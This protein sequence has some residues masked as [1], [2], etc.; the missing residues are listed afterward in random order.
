VKEERAKQQTALTELNETLY[1]K[2]EK[3]L[4][5][6]NDISK[7]DYV[8][9][10]NGGAIGIVDDVKKAEAVVLMG[11]MRMTVKVRDLEKVDA[12]LKQD[13]GRVSTNLE[14][15]V[16]FSNQLDVRGMRRDEVIIEVQ[17]FVD[18]ALLSGSDTL[19]IVHGK[20]DGVLR[21]AVKQKLREYRSIT[22]IYHPE[23]NEGGDG[24]TMVDL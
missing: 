10:R 17:N 5:K 16:R 20:G 8:R 9:M 12:P 19:R 3:K 4:L 14:N 18:E 23:H 24:V 13:K 15:S 11:M 7:G 6:E 1:Y 2:D 22:N 21:T